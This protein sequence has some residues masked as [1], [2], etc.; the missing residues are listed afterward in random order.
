MP[1]YTMKCDV[2]LEG[3][4]MTVVANSKSEAVEKAGKGEWEDI[5]YKGAAL[6]DWEPD[7]FTLLED[8]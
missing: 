4:T 2:K 8:K 3:A 5:D 6:V 7:R 1:T